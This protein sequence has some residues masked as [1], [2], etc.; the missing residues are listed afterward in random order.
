VARDALS[1]AL[2]G[3]SAAPRT[4]AAGAQA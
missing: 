1:A 2:L 3:G 4:A